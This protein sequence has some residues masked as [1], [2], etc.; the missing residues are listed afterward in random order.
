M[1]SLTTMPSKWEY[2]IPAVSWVPTMDQGRVTGYRVEPPFGLSW[3]HIRTLQY[4]AALI[5]Q[6]AGL[7]VRV[8][9]SDDDEALFEIMT[10][11]SIVGG[12]P[13]LAAVRWLD[14]YEVGA[15]EA[16]KADTESVESIPSPAGRL[17]IKE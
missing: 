12:V 1:S 15:S 16:R 10:R 3:P 11:Y 8:T 17:G 9:E 14:A 7:T 6:R 5:G 13:Y 2:E 4:R